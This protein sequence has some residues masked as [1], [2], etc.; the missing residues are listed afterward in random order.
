MERKI[1][2]IWDFHGTDS[3]KKASRHAEHL[4]E[5]MERRQ[6]NMLASGSTDNGE[7]HA[8]AFLTVEEKDVKTLRDILK[9]HRAFVVA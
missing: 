4:G 7:F 8:M 5:F 1:K 3:L 2:L 9:P 6:M